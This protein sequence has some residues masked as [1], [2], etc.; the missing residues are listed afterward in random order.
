MNIVSSAQSLLFDFHNSVTTQPIRGK[1]SKTKWCP[2]PQ[3]FVKI[4]FDAATFRDREGIGAGGIARDDRGNC[5]AWRTGFFGG[6]REAELGKA[7]ELELKFGWE[8][9]VVEGDCLQVIRKLNS[10]ECDF[11]STGPIIA[12][13]HINICEFRTI[14]FM[15]VNRLANS[16]AHMIARQAFDNAGRIIPPAFLYEA[17]TADNPF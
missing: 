15:H 14:S 3:G 7:V 12:D 13:V 2:P 1:T 11:S 6:L 17:I 10:H 5:L 4:N 9:C 16:T 8:R